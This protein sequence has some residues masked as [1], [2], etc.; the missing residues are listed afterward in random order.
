MNEDRTYLLN[1]VCTGFILTWIFSNVAGQYHRENDA[2]RE[3]IPAH[4]EAVLAKPSYCHPLRKLNSPFC[5]A[6]G[7]KL[8][9]YVNTTTNDM[10]YWNDELKGYEETYKKLFFERHLSP[11]NV[12]DECANQMR[13]IGCYFMFPSCDRT[14]GTLKPRQICKETCLHFLRECSVY[15]NAWKDIHLSGSPGDKDLLNCLKQ[16]SV[17][18]GD[19]VECIAYA[20]NKSSESHDCLFLNGSS[21][22]GNISVTAS[23]IPCQSWTEQCPH[24]HTM[25]TTYSYLNNAKNYCRNPQNS[26]KRP[27]CFTT[28]RNK[29]WEYC[30]IPK[31]IKVDGNYGN[32]SLSSACNVTCGGGFEIW[33]RDCNNPEPRFGGRNCS[34]LGEAIEYRPCRTALC[35]VDGNYSDWSKSSGCN[36]SCG[37]GVVTWRRVCN[38]PAP[39]NGG[40]NCTAYGKEI[41]Y[42]ICRKGKC[43]VNGNYSDWIRSTSCSVTC[44]VGYEMWSRTCD[45]PKPKN[46]KDCSQYGKDRESRP[47][48]LGP[49]LGSSNS[50]MIR[51]TCGV[52]AVIIV[53]AVSILLYRKREALMKRIK[54]RDSSSDFAIYAEINFIPRKPVIHNYEEIDP[55]NKVKISTDKTSISLQG[56]SGEGIYESIDN[57]LNGLSS[58][59]PRA[60]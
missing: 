9:T 53:V 42:R 44:G 13:F 43:P 18:A 33:T 38:N 6:H 46:G 11:Q 60:V 14:T 58:E 45:N 56:S 50:N 8:D 2:K 23:G 54:Q 24:R 30:D 36:V 5:A 39:K 57:N 49:C 51:I 12:S 26:G 47:C 28:D 52:C 7:I 27:W 29:R 17:T 25:N 10:Q 34:H 22:N 20:R 41:K 4:T 37:R 31:C 16:P 48:N 19:N 3:C 35:P 15:F 21:Y 32:W 40:K 55:T 1:S 59:M